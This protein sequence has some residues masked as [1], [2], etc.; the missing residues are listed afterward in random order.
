MKIIR[1]FCVGGI[2]ASIDLAL[3]ALAVKVMHIDWFVASLLSFLFATAASYLLSINYVFES[4]VRFK[5]KLEIFLVFLVSCIGL[6]VN[7]TV[8]W[9]LIVHGDLDE[10]LSKIVASSTVFL[11][12]FSSRNLFIFRPNR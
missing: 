5:K 7:Q 8:L 11:W 2:A 1:Y 3:F 4:G 12:N 10:L 9:A 6:I